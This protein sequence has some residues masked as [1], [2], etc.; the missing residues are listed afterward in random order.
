MRGSRELVQDTNL[1]PRQVHA[2][3]YARHGH[4]L[5]GWKSPVG[6]PPS[7]HLTTTTSLRQ[8]RLREGRS[9]GSRRQS[10]EPRNTNVIE[11]RHPRGESAQHDKALWFGGHGKWRGCAAIAHVLIR[12]DLL[13]LRP[14]AATGAGLRPRPKGLDKPPD[15]TTVPAA[16][17]GVIRGVIG[18]KS[19]EAIVGGKAA[20]ARTSKGRTRWRKEEP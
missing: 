19:A 7:T 17:S 15:P 10:C 3:V 9:E 6:E 16:R 12:G 20:A 4:V 8:G 1:R 2:V 11:G 5:M 14:A 18:Q 13:D